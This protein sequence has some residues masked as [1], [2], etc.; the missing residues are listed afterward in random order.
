MS[1]DEL[2]DELYDGVPF[3]AAGRRPGPARVVGID[4]TEASLAA[5]RYALE[6]AY[7]HGGD[8]QAVYAYRGEPRS[9]AEHEA[10]TYAD[11]ALSTLPAAM[12]EASALLVTALEGDPTA[13]LLSAARGAG[14]LVVG[15][16]RSLRDSQ[17]LGATV[18]ACLVA[19]GIPVTLVPSC[20]APAQ[21]G[22]TCRA[23]AL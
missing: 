12:R 1:R 3:D 6:Q 4:G 20:W 10:R 2:Y 8:V 19:E 18:A 5:L 21:H 22:T 17:V 7:I 11:Q 14:G 16:P 23:G 9:A 15:A 13:V